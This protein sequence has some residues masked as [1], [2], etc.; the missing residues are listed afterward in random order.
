MYRKPRGYAGDFLTI[1]WMYANESGGAGELGQLLDRC[2]LNQP[3]AQAV[4]HRR[5]LLKDELEQAL[6]LTDQRH[7]RVTSLA[8]GPAAEV[9]D[10]LL[11]YPELADQVRFTLMDVDVD[12]DVEALIHV[13][14]RLLA[15]GL[16]QAVRLE[17]RNLLHLCI[18]RQ[19]L[20]LSLNT[21]CIR[22][23]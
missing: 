10:V 4:R 21:S 1:E 8:C 22:S 11:Q 5:E 9:F 19:T 12:V 18:G 23:S 17:R 7:L 3:A 2:F 15:H 20:D 13:Q 16:D 6:Q 14:E